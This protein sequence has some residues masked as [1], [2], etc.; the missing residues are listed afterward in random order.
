MAQPDAHAKHAVRQ[1]PATAPHAVSMA[2][3][4]RAAGV[5]QQ[6]V[7]RVVNNQANV[8]EKTRERVLEA[9]ES[10]GFRPNFAGR[11]LRAGAYHAIGL[12]MFDIH[13]AGNL[14]TFE[15]IAS[16]A[17][18]NGYAVTMIELGQT[19]QFSL[20]EAS[21]RMA[22]LPVDG[23]V[24]NVNRMAGDFE[25]FTPL[26]SLNTV[27]LT[28][29]AHPRV[30]TVDSDQYGCSFLAVDHLVAHGHREIRFID[31]ARE[32]I[33]ARFRAAGWRD[34]LEKHRITP[35]VAPY[36][37]D[38]SAESGYEAGVRIAEEDPAATAVF[39]SND[40]MAYGAILALRARG[41]RV[42]EDVSVVGIDDSLTGIV[43]YNDLTTIRFDLN[44]RGRIVFD[45][46]VGSKRG[47][48]PRAVRLPGTLIERGTVAQVRT[49]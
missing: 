47:A 28:M 44:E 45:Y 6:T 43:P 11:S 10:L 5:S 12:C 40:Q 38:W 19:A 29:C 16:A 22:E 39:A 30:T 49:G 26:P 32:S 35:S 24:I 27:L 37:G 18:E 4:A 15:G 48:G 21:R 46:A 17:R 23:I 42:P 13:R 34:A 36:Q 25:T 20:G 41:I 14:A 9:M 1:R 3:V 31:G 2:D 7:S 33:A 8:S